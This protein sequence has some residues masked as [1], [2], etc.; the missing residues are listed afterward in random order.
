[1]PRLL[2]SKSCFVVV[3]IVV[4]VVVIA[5][6]VVS[7]AAAA[8]VVDDQGSKF[9]V[10]HIKHI[11]SHISPISGK[12]TYFAILMKN[13]HILAIFGKNERISVIFYKKITKI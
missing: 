9:Y 2:P 1:M 10:I 3:V 13:S 5:V 11:F 6:V 7:A 8:V 4:V 12:T